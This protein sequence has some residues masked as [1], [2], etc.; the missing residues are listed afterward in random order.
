[1][2]KQKMYIKGAPASALFLKENRVTNEN[3]V[4]K[5]NTLSKV[6]SEV[7]EN[8]VKTKK[9]LGAAK[10]IEIIVADTFF[11]RFSGLMFRQKLPTATGLFL[12]PC[13]SVHMCFMRFA[14]DVVYL[15]KEYNIIKVVKNL[16]P[17]IGLSMCAKAWAVIEMTAGE[18]ER[19]GLTVG[20]KLVPEKVL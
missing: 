6:Y 14:I 8:A 20:T 18:A 4:T 2:Q 5:E 3:T 13:N 10:E 19:C 15:D 7:K 1:M 12:A 17:W 16:K 9:I 11:T